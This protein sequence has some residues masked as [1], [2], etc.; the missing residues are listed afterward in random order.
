M[1]SSATR[2]TSCTST[3]PPPARS[4]APGSRTSERLAEPR[5]RVWRTNAPPEE[6][7]AVD[8]PHVGARH[9]RLHLADMA[10]SERVRLAGEQHEVGAALRDLLQC[11][12]GIALSRPGEDVLD[13]E[14]LQQR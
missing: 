1:S 12:L 5:Q 3:A 14:Q 4:S 8:E 6:V 13:A 11:R 9:D 2:R 10:F 7:A